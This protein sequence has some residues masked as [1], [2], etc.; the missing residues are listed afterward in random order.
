RIA[1]DIIQTPLIRLNIDDSSKEI[2]LKLENFQPTRAYKLRAASNTIRLAN[3]EQLENGVWTIS[4]GNFAQALA[5]I[6]RKLNIGCKILVPD[7]IPQDKEDSIIQL[8]AQVIKAPIE[9][10]MNTLFTREYEGMEG[11][12]IHPFSDPNVMAGSGTI[13]LE[14][15]DE[16]P[17]FD[18]VIIPWGGGG[19]SCG[20]ASA[21][22]ILKQD[23]KIYASEID[24]CSPLAA[25]YKNDKIPDEIP[26]TPSFVDAIGYPFILPE[27]FALAKKLLDGS[28]VVGLE[29]TADVIRLLAKRNCIVSEGAGALSIAAALSQNIGKKIVCI[30]SGG[31]IDSL[32][33]SKIMN[34]KIP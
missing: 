23:V 26:Y 10:A 12:F 19:L 14:I 18:T 17:D 27:M 8:G 5:F 22:R 13:G 30:I 2:F 34:G 4:S 33:L 9:N 16:L 31:N 25:A 11:L 24:T 15:L 32:K 6:A 28:L 29:E 21:I 1:E 3:K 20:I 7:T